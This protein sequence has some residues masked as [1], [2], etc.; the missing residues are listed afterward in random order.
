MTQPALTKAQIIQID[1]LLAEGDDEG[2]IETIFEW[3]PSLTRDQVV[4]II[5][6]IDRR[7]K[8]AQAEAVLSQFLWP[9]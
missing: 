2:A 1:R 8:A 6:D 9:K 7:S 5:D 4:D 3:F